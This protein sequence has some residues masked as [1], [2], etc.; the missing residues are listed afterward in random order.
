VNEV[1]ARRLA[2]ESWPLTEY[3]KREF[4]A[5]YERCEYLRQALQTML[6]LLDEER[7]DGR[8]DADG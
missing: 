3:S 7:N 8:T 5:L 6:L 1:E 4:A 2:A